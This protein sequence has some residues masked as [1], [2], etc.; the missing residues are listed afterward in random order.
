[1]IKNLL[2]LS[3]ISIMMLGCKSKSKRLAPTSSISSE[4]IVVQTKDSS[5]LNLDKFLTKLDSGEFH[6]NTF[7]AKG[8]VNF[9]HNGDA[10]S[11]DIQIRIK[12]NEII[13]FYVN[14]SIVPVAQGY[15]TPTDIKFKNLLNGDYVHKDFS[16]L[17]ELIGIPI[18]FQ[19]LQS[20]LMGNA[21]K[22]FLNDSS[23]L[24]MSTEG[25][26]FIE[27]L[28]QKIKNRL[29]FNSQFRPTRLFLRDSLNNRNV[30]LNYGNFISQNGTF[31][32]Q[33]IFIQAEAPNNKLEIQMDYR[34]IQINPEQDYP[35][36]IPDG[37]N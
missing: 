18:R 23:N 33:S 21:L 28:S 16:Y 32:P 36:Q 26:W 2:Y 11:A 7:N 12:K 4:P 35:F 3:L 1:M 34:R 30:N 29:F 17:Y 15:I 22:T 13:W 31:I 10:H 25:E 20:I 24:K 8:G 19:D 9:N 37:S 5:K 6:F 27:G 14:L